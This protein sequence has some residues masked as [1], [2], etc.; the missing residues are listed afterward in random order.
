MRVL[1]ENG[2]KL[3]AAKVADVA[4]LREFVASVRG[5]KSQANQAT[6]RDSVITIVAKDAP[7][8]AL[9]Q[10]NRDKLSSMAG[11]AEITFADDAG[12]RTGALNSLGTVLLELS[13]TVDVA[14]KRSVSPRN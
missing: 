3:S 8:K 2:I 7:A 10:S 9:L 5:L 14:P 6:R 4:L 1:R 11:L 13:G 12:D